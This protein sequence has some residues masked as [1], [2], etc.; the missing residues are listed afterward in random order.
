MIKN[1]S[2]VG[3]LFLLLSTVVF[4]QKNNEEFTLQMQKLITTYRI[5]NGLYVD[6]VDAEKIVESSV[7]AMLKE[8]DP[9]SAYISADDVERMNEPLQGNFD[10]IGIQFNVLD[11]TLI[12]ISPIPGG[13]SEKVGLRAGDRIVKVDTTII[14]GVELNRNE[15]VKLLRGT[16]GT[17]VQV[18]I[19]R[20]GVRDLLPFMITRD[21][22]PIYSLD[23]AYML[24]PSVGYIKLNRFAATTFAEFEEALKKLKK[25]GMKDL[26]IDLKGNGGGYMQP[27]IQIADQL[28]E[29]DR[30]IVYTE[31][32]NSPMQSYKSHSGGDFEKG[33]LVMLV[34][35]SSASAS[36]ILSGAVQD[37]DRGIIV[38]RRSFGKGLVQKPI[39]LPDGAMLR[40][41]TARYY[42]PSGRCI[43]KPY[44]KGEGKDYGK[45]LMERYDSGELLNADSIHFPDSLKF[46]TLIEGRTVYGG[47]GIIPDVFVPIDT[48]S[49]SDFHRKVV[50]SGVLNEFML[51]YIDNNRDA[52]NSDYSDFE[53]FQKEYEVSEDMFQELVVAAANDSITYDAEEFEVS[54]DYLFLQ[55]RALVAR[56]LFDMSEYYQ[57]M[58]ER[59]NSVLK[60]LEVLEKR[61]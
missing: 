22:I 27:A 13:P 51:T 12:V 6:D 58:N 56:D 42:T 45:D 1:R 26:V 17:K 23:A 29:K 48:T 46:S 53:T 8:L 47:G 33:N 60:A 41:T 20:K 38:G 43:Q 7:I 55:M 36:E 24:S 5:I 14:A 49:Y 35:E 32:N 59:N 44:V 54:H 9:H 18:F 39:N 37:W 3:I 25:A 30:M 57:I 21:K 31:G 50:A 34:D 52:L 19:K 15:M 2:L 40:L 61:K 16:K 10:G 28:L 11:D 4:S